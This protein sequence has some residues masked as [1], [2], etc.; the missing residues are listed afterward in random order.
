MGWQRRQKLTARDKCM[1][2]SFCEDCVV[3]QVRAFFLGRFV[4]SVVVTVALNVA[5]MLLNDPFQARMKELA[6]P[7]HVLGCE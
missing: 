4:A 5:T 7:P 6:G 3:A 2:G 1:A